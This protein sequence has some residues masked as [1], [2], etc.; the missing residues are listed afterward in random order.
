[1]KSRLTR[2]AAS[3][4]VGSALAV[5]AG[6]ISASAQEYGGEL[7]VVVGSKI[8][9][10]DGHIESTFGM[11]H[12]IRPFYSTLI[13]INPDN[14]SSPTDFVCDL[15]VGDVPEPTEN[16]TKYTFKIRTGVT[17]Q[18]GTPLTSADVKATFDKLAFPPEGIASNRKAYF[19]MIDSIEAPDAETLIFNLKFP[20][21]TFIPSVAMPFN[22]VYSKNDLDTHGYTWHQTNINGSGPFHFVEHVQGSH[23]SGK[24]NPNYYHEGMPYLDGYRAISAPKM[25]VRLQAI[26]GGQADIEFR[27]FPPKARDDLV[28]ALGDQITVQE[29]DWNCVLLV[30]PNHQVK[31]FDDARVRQALSLA[32]DRAGGSKYLSQIAI[33]KTVGGIGFPGHPISSSPEY[34]EKNIIGYGSDIEANR[35]KAKA[36]LKE[37]G[38][39][40]LKFTLHNRGVDQPYKVVGTWLIDQWKRIG[41]DVEQWVQPSTP[42][43]A[44]LRKKKDFDV[45]VD[46]NCQAVVNPIADISKFLPSGGANYADF[47]DQQLED[48]YNELLQTGDPAKQRELFAAYEKRVL[49]DLASQF[50]TLWWYKINPYR[51]YVKG[52]KIAPSHYLNQ[53]LENIWIDQAEY[54]KQLGG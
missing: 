12:P 7:R 44:T 9:S 49:N 4:V 14:P 25:S 48:I 17:F 33:V 10:Y 3:V 5:G 40:N 15:C 29:S 53:S 2:F 36:L 46:F 35:E 51:S 1:M 23:V 37:A 20:S 26:R 52:W 42:F 39:E 11:I 22:F 47:E 50:I 31:P 43:Y 32:I 27:G 21:G 19:K 6:S 34:L 28:N 41:L 54:K 13:R 45:S 38:H 30:T 18:D 8:P 24:K 16:G